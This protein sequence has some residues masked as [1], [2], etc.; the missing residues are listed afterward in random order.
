M[1]GI[2]DHTD[3]DFVVEVLAVQRNYTGHRRLSVARL[4]SLVLESDTEQAVQRSDPDLVLVAVVGHDFGIHTLPVA[5]GEV[6]VEVVAG[7]G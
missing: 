2:V 5:V 3:A 6:V 1:A 7:V 4:E